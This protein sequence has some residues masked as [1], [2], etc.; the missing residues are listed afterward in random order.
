MT[1]P[2]QGDRGT[3]TSGVVVGVGGGGIR[4]NKALFGD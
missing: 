3:G 2:A 4:D 1:N